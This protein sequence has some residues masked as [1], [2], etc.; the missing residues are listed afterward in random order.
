M[1]FKILII[2]N[3]GLLS[4]LYSYADISYIGGGFGRGIH[5]I[6]EAAVF[7]TPV[8][9]GPKYKKFREAKNLI[10][11]GGAVTI[12][13]LGQLERAF[14]S[15]SNDS[16]TINSI[17]IINTEYINNNRGATKIIMHYINMNIDM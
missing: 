14:N 1:D 8:I 12:N 17:K 6:L 13:N 15:F 11:L 10:K 7:G 9:F 3:I 2:D 16:D 4:S 5:N